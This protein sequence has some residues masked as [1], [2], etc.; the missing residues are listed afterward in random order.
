MAESGLAER[1]LAWA[2]RRRTRLAGY[3]PWEVAV[4]VGHEV[5]E[6]RVT[7][8]AAEMAFF[9]LLSL[10][11][12]LVAFGAAL[13]YASRVLD[14]DDLEQLE[15]L[16]L[17]A[18]NAVFGP[19][20]TADLLEPLVSGLLFEGRG[21][22]AL[23]SL[24]VAL[25]LGSRVFT[26]TIRALDQA[27]DVEERR[28]LV[29][30]RLLA[31]GYAGV[32]IVVVPAALVFMVLGPLL[33]G[34]AQLAGRL[35]LGSVFAFFWEVVRWPT[36]VLVVVGF[37]A[38]V[39]R[40]GPHVSNRWRDCLPGAVLGVA[41]WAAATVGFRVYLA[42]GGG[43]GQLGTMDEAVSDMGRILGSFVATILW[44]YLA[45]LAILLGGELNAELAKLRQQ[46]TAEGQPGPRRFPRRRTA[47]RAP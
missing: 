22:L 10:V 31:L 41:L 36:F 35:G 33:G 17:T 40:F 5:V 20:L 23:S 16:V 39:Y 2:R 4:R 42:V 38:F 37:L 12:M 13:G 24:A 9:A 34:G 30:Q 26:A 27:Y 18:L 44:T 14:P 15:Q 1:A 11:P 47:R 45:S 3:N 25:Y 32:S 8:L 28:G 46:P 29:V 7:G 6:D 21:G 19:R 43:T